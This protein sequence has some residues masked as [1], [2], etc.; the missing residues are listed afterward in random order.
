MQRQDPAGGEVVAVLGMHVLVPNASQV[1]RVRR[2]SSA[3]AP[4]RAITAPCYGV[5]AYRDVHDPQLLVRLLPPNHIANAP[6]P[7]YPERDG[8][9]MEPST[10]RALTAEEEERRPWER[11]VERL[12]AKDAAFRRQIAEESLRPLDAWPALDT[13]CRR[14]LC[15][16]RGGKRECNVEEYEA[17]EAGDFVLTV[18][19]EP[20]D[21]ND[22]GCLTWISKSIVEGYRVRDAD[23]GEMRSH[24]FAAWS[25]DSG[26]ARELAGLHC[27]E[28]AWD[29]DTHANPPDDLV[30]VHVTDAEG[31]HGWMLRSDV[32]AREAA[33]P[34]PV[35]LECASEA[36]PP[37]GRD[38]FIPSSTF[39]GAKPGYSFKSGGEGLGYYRD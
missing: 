1:L 39:A 8:V 33:A 9:W 7:E 29:R 30:M 2:T 36:G 27:V 34:L 28:L 35:R 17:A 14:R 24:D 26:M 15:A 4:M 22:F 20:G 13:P 16:P 38:P 5:V 25:A 31:K 23:S 19:A 11:A 3:S 6:H 12:D 18:S 32:C 37:A 10:L 21:A